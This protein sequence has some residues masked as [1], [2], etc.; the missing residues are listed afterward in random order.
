MRYVKWLIRLPFLLF[1]LPFVLAI[2]LGRAI[3]WAFDHRIT[4]A[5][6][7]YWKAWLP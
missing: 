3:E 5:N 1:A 6:H 7:G 4:G 2:E